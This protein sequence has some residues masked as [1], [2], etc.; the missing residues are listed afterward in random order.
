MSSFQE[1]KS[2]IREAAIMDLEKGLKN[3][4]DAL[5]EDSSHFNTILLRLGQYNSTNRNI[6]KGILGGQQAEMTF[7]Q[8]RNALLEVLNDLKENDVNLQFSNNAPP[9]VNQPPSSSTTSSSGSSSGGNPEK[10][11][12]IPK[13]FISYAH[14][15]DKRYFELLVDGIKTFS[16]WEIFDD[17]EIMLGEG[18]HERLQYE[19]QECDFAVFLLSQHFFNSKYIQEEEFQHFISRNAKEGFLFFSI[20]LTY[21]DFTQ[22]EAIAR[23]QIFVAHGQDYGLGKTDRDQQ[24]TFAQLV[25][26]DRD[27]E[28]IPNDYLNRFFRNFVE[29]ANRAWHASLRKK[30]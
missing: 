16:N 10:I 17:R 28:L 12:K 5:R 24:I 14:R 9:P 29:A 30:S 1:F 19:V 23:N 26:Y 11:N 13:V 25:N 22:W 6:Q 4:K 27:G 18:W 7:A 15:T 8:I 20:L 2:G 21:C 3:L